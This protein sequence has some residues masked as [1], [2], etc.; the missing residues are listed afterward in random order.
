MTNSEL[1]L[2]AI[3]GRYGT[4]DPNQLQIQRWSYW[5]YVR[6]PVAGTNRLT[7]M[8]NP[9]GSV[10]P[11]SGLAKTLEETN[12]RRS[13][14]LDLPFV[15]MAVKTVI[16]VLPA[17]RQAA[18]YVAVTDAVQAASTPVHRVLRNMANLGVLLVDFGQKN[19]FTIEQPFQKCPPGYGPSIRSVSANQQGTSGVPDET[20]YYS[21]SVDPRDQYVVSPP[22]FIEKGQTFQCVI[23]FLLTN[24]PAIP[25]VGGVNVA[26]NVG[27]EFDGYVIRPVQ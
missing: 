4:Q 24:T 14:E 18:G 7:F 9:I 22:V 10:D 23:D 19:Q 2:Q 27:L 13:G 16:E 26:V 6:L 20:L 3:A 5:D 1:V 25:Q 11:V 17:G 15:I 21:Q 12:I 8:S